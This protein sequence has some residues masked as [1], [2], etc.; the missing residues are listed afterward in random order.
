MVAK[1]ICFPG[2]RAKFMQNPLLLKFLQSTTPLTL[3]ES[4]YDKLCGTGI[5][6]YDTNALKQTHW[7]NQGILGEILSRIRKE[8]KLPVE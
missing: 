2:I 5:S 8:N 7:A 6:L 4:S 1:D 3:A